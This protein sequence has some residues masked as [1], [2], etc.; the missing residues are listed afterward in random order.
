MAHRKAP[1]LIHSAAIHLLRSVARVDDEAGVGPA[2]LSAVSVLYFAGPLTLRGLADA[3]RVTPPTMSRVVD[4][5]ERAGLARRGRHPD[6]ARAVLVTLSA[7]GRRLF[8]RAR[9][10][11]LERLEALFGNASRDELATLARAA[12]IVERAVRG[13]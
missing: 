5:L 4:N 12:E 13:A 10:R 6:D 9:R 3:E 1:D 7:K 2:Q 8:E 11:R